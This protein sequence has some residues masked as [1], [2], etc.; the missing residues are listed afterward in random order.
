MIRLIPLGLAVPGVLAAMLVG[1][2]VLEYHAA[3]PEDVPLPSLSRPAS[4]RTSPSAVPSAVPSAG[5]DDPRARVEAILA[6][7]LFRPSRRPPA[8]PAGGMAGLPRLSG[9]LVSRGLRSV[10]FAEGPEGKSVVVAQGGH[11]GP[12]VVTAIGDGEAVVSGPG[13]SRTLRPAFGAGPP[14]A[15]GPLA[16][17]IPGTGAVA[18]HQPTIL[19]LLEH[20]PPPVFGIPGLPP[21]P[22]PRQ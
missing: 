13:G 19:E 15:A 22:G 8:M 11:V 14:T 21:P 6:R 2:L 18:P 16:G 9:V 20:G 7:P 1:V 4:L 5:Q 12:Y 10:I 17:A 3:A